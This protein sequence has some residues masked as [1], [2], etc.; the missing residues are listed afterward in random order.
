M[1]V[2]ATAEVVGKCLE[3]HSEVTEVTEVFKE[4]EHL[5]LTIFKV[6]FIWRDEHSE[7]DNLINLVVERHI[8]QSNLVYL[9]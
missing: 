6:R 8:D 3:G 7:E 5:K 1:P 4:A 2:S 9:R